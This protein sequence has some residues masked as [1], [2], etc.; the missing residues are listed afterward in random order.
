M[1]LQ[2]VISRKNCVKKL[3]FCWHLE[4]RIRAKMSG[5]R[6]T[7]FYKAAFGSCGLEFGHLAAVLRA[8]GEILPFVLDVFSRI[9]TSASSRGNCQGGETVI[10]IR[11][12]RN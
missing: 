9:R 5:I 1:Y 8:R 6:N 12:I 10:R 4:G 11:W 3:V 2:K 7:D